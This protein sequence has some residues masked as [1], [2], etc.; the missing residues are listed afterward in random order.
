MGYLWAKWA[1]FRSG[2]P[3]LGPVTVLFGLSG[4]G[5]GVGSPGGYHMGYIQA[6]YGL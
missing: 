1:G 5:L 4:H 2:R 3:H 6:L